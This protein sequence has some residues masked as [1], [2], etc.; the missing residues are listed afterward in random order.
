LGGISLVL[1][2]YAMHLVPIN[3]AGLLL[4]VL[5]LALFVLEAK[6]PTHGILGVGGLVAMLLG[7]LMLV[8]SPL[9]GAGVSLG[10]ALGATL[11]FA[12][13]SIGLMRLVL[14]SRG[15]APQVGVD[16]LTHDTGEVA[17]P[18]GGP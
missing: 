4:L 2:L 7:A 15:W 13:L 5:A 1:A 6:F 14:R 17:E 8:R 3:L 18:I 10:V 9:T 16:E 12:A 11:P